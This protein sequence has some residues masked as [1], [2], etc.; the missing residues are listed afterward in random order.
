MGMLNELIDSVLCKHN[1][2]R[3]DGRNPKLS[4]YIDNE[5]WHEIMSSIKG[6]VSG[7]AFDLYNNGGKYIY[8]YPIYRVIGENIG[9]RIYEEPTL[10][11]EY[12]MNKWIEE[13]SGLSKNK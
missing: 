10:A 9:F 2:M 4:I 6:S 13:L 1:N 7:I 11:S 8:G 12:I 5:R 3:R